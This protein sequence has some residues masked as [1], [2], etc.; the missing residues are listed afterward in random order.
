M[1]T[2]HVRND[3][4]ALTRL[5]TQPKN[6]LETVSNP[7]DNETIQSIEAKA[8]RIAEATGMC[9][10]VARIL[11][12]RKLIERLTDKM[13]EAC[14]TAIDAGDSK[15]SVARAV[16]KEPTNLFNRNSLLGARI[17]E[18]LLTLET[19]RATAKNDTAANT[20]S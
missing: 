6:I 1:N 13:V 8:K 18:D 16:G 5:Y 9:D 19:L 11:I 2:Q 17:Q 20:L 12:T 7:L 14:V 15:N 10:N 3:R 4:K